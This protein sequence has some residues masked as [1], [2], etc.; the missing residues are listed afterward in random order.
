MCLNIFL[1]RSN[2]W[3]KKVL[4]NNFKKCSLMQCT[5]QF[6]FSC[7]KR[8]NSNQWKMI[9]TNILCFRRKKKFSLQKDVDQYMT[10]SFLKWKSQAT[11]VPDQAYFL[12]WH[13]KYGLEK[14]SVWYKFNLEVKF[15]NK[16]FWKIRKNTL[17]RKDICNLWVMSLWVQS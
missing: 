13:F 17:E 12:V 11:F 9:L 3:K 15:I 4:K 1:F 16:W 8:D 10:L 14:Y 6:F 5:S 2:F 7:E